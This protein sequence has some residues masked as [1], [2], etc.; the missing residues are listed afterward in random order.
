[1]DLKLQNICWSTN[2]IRFTLIKLLCGNGIQI[3]QMHVIKYH[4]QLWL[5]NHDHGQNGW[6]DSSLGKTGVRKQ[7]ALITK[8]PGVLDN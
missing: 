3:R 4:H 8:I 5:V 2:S 6:L 1:M 7:D